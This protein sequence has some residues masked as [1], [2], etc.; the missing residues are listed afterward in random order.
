MDVYLFIREDSKY[1]LKQS[2]RTSKLKEPFMNVLFINDKILIFI[3][4]IVHS[5]DYMIPAQ[6]LHT[7]MNMYKDFSNK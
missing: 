1:K 4:R 6:A 2:Y 5:L 7:Y 3:V